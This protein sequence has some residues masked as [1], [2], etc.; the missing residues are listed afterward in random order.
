MTS[1]HRAR[2]SGRPI[3]PAWWCGQCRDPHA[4]CLRMCRLRARRQRQALAQGR[5]HY[6]DPSPRQELVL[7]RARTQP[8]TLGLGRGPC[9]GCRSIRRG[10]M[11]LVLILGLLARALKSARCAWRFLAG[12]QQ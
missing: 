10:L 9:S 7:A 5:S 8:R 4:G 3:I 2:V 1:I 6:R 12:S 11:R